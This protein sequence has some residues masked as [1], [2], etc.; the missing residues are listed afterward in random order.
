[1][2]PIKSVLYALI[3][4][5]WVRKRT[6]V[7]DDWAGEWHH[8]KVTE[9]YDGDTITVEVYR[10]GHWIEQKVR[11]DGIDT[12]EL[13]PGKDTPHRAAVV[14]SATFAR[15]AVVDRCLFKKVWIHCT[16]REKYGRIL[17]KVYTSHQEDVSVN[18]W[19]VSEG[20]AKYYDGGKKL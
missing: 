12:P 18:D 5:P 1:M 20:F 8:V 3:V 16:G 9:V 17:A 6:P 7:R 2:A 11:L 15:A 10:H 14:A 13:H 19:L 4:L